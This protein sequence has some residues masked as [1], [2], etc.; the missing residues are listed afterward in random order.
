MIC[1]EA[2][3]GLVAPIVPNCVSALSRA[4]IGLA[5]VRPSL[6]TIG[7]R[8][9]TLKVIVRL[10]AWIAIAMAPSCRARTSPSDVEAQKFTDRLTTAC[11]HTEPPGDGVSLT[12]T[13]SASKYFSCSAT[14]MA[15]KAK[16]G[17]AVRIDTSG[18]SFWA[19]TWVIVPKRKSEAVKPIRLIRDLTLF[20]IFNP[21]S[22]PGFGHVLFELANSGLAFL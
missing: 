13:P 22:T 12:R 14:Q 2:A 15:P 10:C 9:A 19:L 17:T 11:K 4:S 1:S 7:L 18:N 3:P 21:L 8:T 5:R 20:F 6:S 16:L